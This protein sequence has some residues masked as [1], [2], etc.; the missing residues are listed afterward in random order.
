MGD[1][2]N[3]SSFD[4][5]VI[6]WLRQRT[7]PMTRHWLDILK[8]R[9]SVSPVRIFPDATLLNHI[10]DLLD[11]L[12]SGLGEESSLAADPL[13]QEELR[14]LARLRRSQGYTLDELVAEFHALRETIANEVRAAACAWSQAVRPEDVLD[15]CYRLEL[16]LNFIL[17]ETGGEYRDSASSDREARA[18]LLS[19][20]G[21]AITHELRGRLNNA[22][23]ALAVYRQRYESGAPA[24]DADSL[25]DT[26]EAALARLEGVAADVFAAVV[27]EA[28]LT[29]TPGR[30]LPF[31]QLARDTFEELSIFAEQRDVE[32]RLPGELPSFQIDAPRLHLVLVNLVTNAIKYAD[33][34]KPKRWVEL[35][36]ERCDGPGEW[37]IDVEDNGV[38]IEPGLRE[39]IFRKHIRSSSNEEELGEGLGLSLAHEAVSQLG[40]RLW[41]TGEP[42]EGSTFSFSLREPDASLTVASDESG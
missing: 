22:V 26:L 32:L 42:G 8:E 29:D 7:R 15:F 30:R 11:R 4:A 25:L 23:L 24:A 14:K 39:H 6:G 37:R 10:P 36:A 12:F 41:V 21:R 9:L 35:R 13:V 17:E 40:G 19:A 34:R 3:G 31:D 27:S 1:T 16:T 2:M 38:G 33:L 5:F 20:F 18:E 28:R